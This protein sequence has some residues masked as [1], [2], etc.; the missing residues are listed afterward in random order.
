MGHFTSWSTQCLLTALGLILGFNSYCIWAKFLIWDLGL[1]FVLDLLYGLNCIWIFFFIL[2]GLGH[3][4]STY[5][6]FLM[7][8]LEFLLVVAESGKSGA[9]LVWDSWSNWCN[10]MGRRLTEDRN[11]SIKKKDG[12]KKGK[13]EDFECPLSLYFFEFLCAVRSKDFGLYFLI[14][15]WE[16][17]ESQ[18]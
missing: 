6:F 3:I 12:S 11:V 14:F 4:Y 9:M 10:V 13:W 7:F 2:I 17:M 15:V 18:C 5:S 8:E 1:L 16:A